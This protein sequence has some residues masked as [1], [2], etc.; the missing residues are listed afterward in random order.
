MERK[1]DVIVVGAGLAGLKAARELVAAGRSVIV[2]EANERVGG[3]LKRDVIG[4]RNVDTG[5]Q[6]VGAGHSMLFDE[7][8]RMGI[9]AYPQ[10]AS[11][12]TLLQLAGKLTSFTGE[13]PR[14]PLLGLIEVLFLQRRWDREMATI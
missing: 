5:G 14:M 6:W 8:R 13:I 11:G 12:R 1:A 3:R 2:L 10:Y 9:E 4:D 7:A